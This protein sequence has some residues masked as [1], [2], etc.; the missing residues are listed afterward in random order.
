MATTT[1]SKMFDSV[2]MPELTFT[3]KYMGGAEET[4]E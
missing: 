1:S 3:V 2:M 4:G